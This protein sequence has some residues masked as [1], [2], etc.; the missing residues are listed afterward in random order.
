MVHYEL[1][2]GRGETTVTVKDAADL[3]LKLCKQEWTSTEW[4]ASVEAFYVELCSRYP[5]I[6]T[7]PDDKFDNCPWSCAHDRSGHHIIM[8]LN[9]G[10]QLEEVAMFVTRLAARHDLICYDPQGQKVYSPPGLKPKRS[11][12]QLW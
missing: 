4:Y 2:S 12:F 3:Y 8:C 1:R 9:Y 5:E 11:R 7:L 6:D 10:D